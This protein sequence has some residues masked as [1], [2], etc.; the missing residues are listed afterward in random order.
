MLDVV[1]VA[2]IAFFASRIFSEAQQHRD[3]AGQVMQAVTESVDK[4]RTTRTT[5]R[6]SAIQLLNGENPE[7]EH[8]SQHQVEAIV[9]QCHNSVSGVREFQADQ[10]ASYIDLNA[11]KG[12]LELIDCCQRAASVSAQ[13]AQL[14][15]QQELAIYD[16]RVFLRKLI[17]ETARLEGRQRLQR[18]QTMRKLRATSE[19][20]SAQ[21]LDELF[22]HQELGQHVQVCRTNLRDTSLLVERIQSVEDLDQ[23]RSLRENQLSQVLSRLKREAENT[24]DSI[25]DDLADDLHVLNSMLFSDEQNAKGLFQIKAEQLNAN[26]KRVAISE[27]LERITEY[28]EVVE[29]HMVESLTQIEQSSKQAEIQLAKNAITNIY[30]F[31]IGVLALFL[32]G[33][34][35]IAKLGKNSEAQLWQK[36]K[37]SSAPSRLQRQPVVPRASFWPT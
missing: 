8:L 24:Q 3:A 14:Q 1:A 4:L 26:A 20:E 22:A 36:T 28:C 23:L 19:L 30:A 7:V 13:A 25:H 18:A 2:V 16:L 15:A 12:M 32:T 6:S 10:L 5:L 27:K 29:S 31:T 11:R 35:R 37:Y 33:A 9:Q 34:W 17:A 21:V